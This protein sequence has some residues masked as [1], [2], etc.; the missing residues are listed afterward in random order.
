MMMM[1]IMIMIMMNVDDDDDVDADDDDDDDDDELADV[2][3]LILGV[4]NY[5]G[6]I[7]C[8]SYHKIQIPINHFSNVC[9][10]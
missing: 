9:V 1:P 8:F 2:S 7:Q 4:G 6:C 10:S 3:G 5:Q